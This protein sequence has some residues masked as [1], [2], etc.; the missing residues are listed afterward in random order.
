[1][2]S[3]LSNC[4][5]ILF[6]A[7]CLSVVFVMIGYWL[8]K[9]FQDEDVCLVDYKP[10]KEANDIH[11]PEVSLCF[12]YPGPLYENI[13]EINFTHL[14]INMTQY[15]LRTVVVWKNGSYL[16]VQEAK[17]YLSFSGFKYGSY[18]KCFSVLTPDLDWGEVKFIVHW[19]KI[20]LYVNHFPA[21]MEGVVARIHQPNQFLHTDD[22][23]YLPS[24]MDV[25]E[26]VSL[27]I[28]MTS[29]EVMKRRNKVM[30]PCMTNWNKFDEI[31]TTE[32][33]REF[34]CS[35][36]YFEPSTH[37]PICSDEKTIED[38]RFEVSRIRSKPSYFPPCQ[39]MSKIDY[40]FFNNFPMT[41]GFL[42]IMI[43]YP[44]QV[45]IIT[46]SQAVDVHTIVGNIGGYIGLFLGKFWTI[47]EK[48]FLQSI[49]K[50]H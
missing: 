6:K 29:F 17:P 16:S 33:K 43:G 28:L 2:K 13:S 47:S 5:D 42:K 4:I 7:L 11:Y 15:F 31:Y 12:Q 26:G 21:S 35:P 46:Q 45:K 30:E 1:M 14:S 37:F 41:K 25:S 3:N 10:I 18:L 49:S 34:R 19:Y 32:H 40:D 44:E 38:S 8:I 48:A 50:I 24:N 27:G 23:Q 9:Y 39:G 20:E 22:A 36:P